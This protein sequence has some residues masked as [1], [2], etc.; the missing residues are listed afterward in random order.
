M[1]EESQEA[2]DLC[3]SAKTFPIAGQQ[4]QR[5]HETSHSGL[6]QE[7]AFECFSEAFCHCFA[8]PRTEK[9]S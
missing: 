1:R 7:Q 8:N 9:N 3:K 5:P 4:R 2:E 6:E